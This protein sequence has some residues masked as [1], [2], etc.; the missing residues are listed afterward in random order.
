MER[1]SGFRV[2]FMV[3]LEERRGGR[4]GS[5]AQVAWPAHTQHAAELP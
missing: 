5:G 3:D 2:L 4:T 1:E